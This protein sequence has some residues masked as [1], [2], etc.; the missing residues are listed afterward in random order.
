[1]HHNFYTVDDDDQIWRP[2]PV[3]ED[4]KGILMSYAWQAEAFLLVGLKESQA[5][6]LAVNVIDDLHDGMDTKELFE[7]GRVQA[8]TSDP[9][10]FGG[11]VM[12]PPRHYISVLYLMQRSWRNV[13]FGGEAISFAP[14]WVQGALESGLRAAYQLYSDDQSTHSS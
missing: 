6:R 10:T 7:L 12:F 9:T 3:T 1:M 2:A 4:Q 11:F 5:V 13:Y 14:G 8:W